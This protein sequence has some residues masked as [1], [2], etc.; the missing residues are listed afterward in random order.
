MSNRG[1]SYYK[2]GAYMEQLKDKAKERGANIPPE[3]LGL[4]DRNAMECMLMLLQNYPYWRSDMPD[5][6]TES[7]LYE[8]IMYYSATP[9]V[10]SRV[11]N[12]NH[13]EI[14]FLSGLEK[15][16]ALESTGFSELKKHLIQPAQVF[17]LYGFMGQGKT[18]LAEVMG[19]IFEDD[20]GDDADVRT[21]LETLDEF[22]TIQDF[23]SLDD[24][25]NADAD[26]SKSKEKLFIFD[27]AGSH[28][29]SLTGKQQAQTYNML[30]PV[31]KQIRKARG[32]IILIGQ[33]GMDLA[34][35]IRRLA[36]SIEKTG[37][38]TATVY[39]RGEDA[40]KLFDLYNIPMPS[41]AY[42]HNTEREE[43]AEWSWDTDEDDGDWYDSLEQDERD[44]IVDDLYNN[45]MSQSDI[46][47][48]D[49]IGWINSK[50]SVSNVLERV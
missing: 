41:D 48:S 25:L 5:D 24:W 33:S 46:A 17:Y 23:G 30:L 36:L 13:A 12:E 40:D 4:E 43:F 45:G 10:Q 50:G 31:I 35:D 11:R 21:N 26:A 49:V 20:F 15:V 22:E 47:R 32:R 27:E 38:K 37:E 29:T 7:D 1:L 14:S 39:D 9:A 3:A 6:V 18:M 44:K 28:A 34:K 8:D 42:K 16:D 2:Y 19:E